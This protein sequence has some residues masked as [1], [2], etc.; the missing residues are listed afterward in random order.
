MAIRTNNII[1]IHPNGAQFTT[2]HLTA[3][4]GYIYLSHRGWRA[5]WDFTKLPQ[6]KR[7]KVSFNRARK[8]MY[9]QDIKVEFDYVKDFDRVRRYIEPYRR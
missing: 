4:P 6:K 2:A 5:F 9:I 8:L 1:I 7:P 3:S